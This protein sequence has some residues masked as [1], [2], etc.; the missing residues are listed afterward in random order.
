MHTT[1][2]ADPIRSTTHIYVLEDPRTKTVRYIGKGRNPRK[3]LLRSLQPRRLN[4]DHTP[5]ARWLQDLAGQGLEPKIRILETVTP[6]Q[7]AGAQQRW[8]GHYQN[9]VGE[10]LTNPPTKPSG[11]TRRPG[12]RLNEEDIQEIRRLSTQ[13]EPVAALAQHYGVAP[14]HI[15]DLLAGTRRVTKKQRNRA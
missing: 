12:A 2:T 8:I 13:G 4:R 3:S 6:G 10:Q 11:Q 14:S 7:A 5:L 1:P 9:W 15:S